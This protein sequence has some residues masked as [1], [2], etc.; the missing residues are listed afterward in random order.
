MVFFGMAAWQIAR[1]ATT[2]W[3]SGEV[4]ET[5][6]IVYYPFTYGIAFSCFVLALVFFVDLLKS[7]AG[8]EEEK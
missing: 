6:Q 2:L 3:E 8:K 5:L 7:F 1:W 4:T